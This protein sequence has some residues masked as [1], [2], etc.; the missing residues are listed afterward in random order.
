MAYFKLLRA[1]EWEAFAAQGRFAGSPVDLQDGF[2]HLS[3]AEQ[4]EETARR[5]FAGE[6]GLMLLTL[7]RT[8]LGPLIRME[9]SRGGELFP[10][11][12][13][14]LE[15]EDVLFAQELPLEHGRHIFPPLLP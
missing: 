15:I 13:R 2:V 7:D 3:A 14:G 9:P 11:L 10:H 5:H 1:S 8:R 6:A 4:V 12:Y